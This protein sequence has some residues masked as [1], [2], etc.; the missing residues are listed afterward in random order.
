MQ[1]GNEIG[2]VMYDGYAAR[3]DA[4]TG[5]IKWK[6]Q[7]NGAADFSSIAPYNDGFL[8]ISFGAVFRRIGLSVISTR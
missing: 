1:H 4:T 2:I 8:V 5:N 7:I 3:L 6:T